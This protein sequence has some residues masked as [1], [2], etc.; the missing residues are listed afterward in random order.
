MTMLAGFAVVLSRYSGQEDLAV[1]TP[2]ANRTEEQLEGMIGFFVNTLVM[3]VGV[4][5]GES[6]GELLGQVRRVALGAYQHQEVPFERLVEELSPERSLNRSPIF[7][8]VFALQNAPWKRQELVGL[9]VEALGGRR[10][11]GAL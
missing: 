10:G 4:K 1:G 11:A 3:R 6:V 8:V 7:Q 2:I 9:E 5:E